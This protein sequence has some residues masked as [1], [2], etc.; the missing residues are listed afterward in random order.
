MDSTTSREM[1]KLEPL[2]TMVYFAAEAREEYAAFGLDNQATQYFPA[3]AAAL[4]VV[5]WQVVQAT[6]FGFSP[7]AVE[8]GMTGV[9]DRVSPIDLIAARYRAV[10][11]ALRRMGGELSDDPALKEAVDLYRTATVDLPREGRPLYAAHAALP[12]PDETLLALWH[13][14]TL[15]REFR[16]DG[17]LAVLLARGVSAP[18]SLVLNGAYVGRGMTDFLKQSRA[19]SEE[20]WSEAVAQLTQRGLVAADGSLTAEGQAFRRAIE[21]ETDALALPMW[22][23]IGEDGCSRLREIV[24]PLVRAVVDAGG[25]PATSTR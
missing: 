15:A 12:W 7:F 11:R 4:G 24:L 16:G 25:I 13:G 3:R 20:Q 2:H 14:Q 9:W 18:Q 1:H 21:D 6:F 23:R 19:W 5:P 8:I 10:D 22:Q 17:H